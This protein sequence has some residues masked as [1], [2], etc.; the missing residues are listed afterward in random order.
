MQTVDIYRGATT[1]SQLGFQ[2][3]GLGYY[4]PSTEKKTRQV[5]PVWCS[6]LQNHALFIKKLRKKL[7]HFVQFLGQ[8]DRTP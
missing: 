2:F 6:R 4:Y 7:G 8:W 3:L 5:Y 1:S